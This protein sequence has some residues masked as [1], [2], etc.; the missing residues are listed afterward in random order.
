VGG[1]L[2]AEPLEGALV[3]LEVLVCYLLARSQPGKVFDV[4]EGLQPL[5]P[6]DVDNKAGDPLAA[7][8]GPPHAKG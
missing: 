2:Q 5:L 6:K 8:S 3:D 4:D 1:L 7:G